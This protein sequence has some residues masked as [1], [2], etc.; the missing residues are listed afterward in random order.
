MTT[1]SQ[2][3][4]KISPPKQTKKQ[5]VEEAPEVIQNVRKTRFSVARRYGRVVAY[6]HTYVYRRESD[7]LIR[8]DVFKQSE[9]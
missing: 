8:L 4:G 1:D 2:S 5:V 6:G 3:N 7:S 9:Q